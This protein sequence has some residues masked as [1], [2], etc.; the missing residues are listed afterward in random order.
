MWIYLLIILIIL[1]ILINYNF[2]NKKEQF[3]KIN[4]VNTFHKDFEEWNTRRM[5][6][7]LTYT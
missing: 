4:R 1:I 5:F 3:I 2:I 7:V 6:D